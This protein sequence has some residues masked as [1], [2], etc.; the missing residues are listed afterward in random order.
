METIIIPTN[1]Y[2]EPPIDLEYKQY[3]LLD[4]LQKV[5]YSFMQKKLS[6]HFLNLEKMLEEL[7]MF[8]KTYDEMNRI[9]SKQRYKYF[10]DNSKIEG[11]DEKNILEIKD[12]VDFSIPQITVRIEFGNKILIKTKQILY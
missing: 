12:I 10:E 4:Y 2:I 7:N 1:W 9:F 3:V 6:P 8:L 5:D 11:Y